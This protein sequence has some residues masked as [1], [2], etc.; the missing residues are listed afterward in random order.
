MSAGSFLAVQLGI[1][2]PGDAA[3]VLKLVD[4]FLVGSSPDF[5]LAPFMPMALQTVAGILRRSMRT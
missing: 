5:G 1:E 3:V 4:F 2:V